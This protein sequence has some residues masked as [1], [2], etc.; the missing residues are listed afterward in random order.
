VARQM[1]VVESERT[2]IG[3]CLLAAFGGASRKWSIKRY[4]RFGLSV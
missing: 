4:T 3:L 1:L 2:V